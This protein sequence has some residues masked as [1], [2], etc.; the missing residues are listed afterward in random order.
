MKR[1]IPFLKE[2]QLVAD[3]AAGYT[4]KPNVDACGLDKTECLFRIQFC[5]KIRSACEGSI[6]G[7]MF[8]ADVFIR[9]EL[10]VKV[11]WGRY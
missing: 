11:G 7:A 3:N 5:R 2:K 8:L 9:A 1:L 10:I 6:H 4:G